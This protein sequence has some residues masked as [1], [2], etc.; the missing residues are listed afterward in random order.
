MRA[1]LLVGFVTNQLREMPKL[2]NCWVGGG[3]GQNDL[4]DAGLVG[5]VTH[6]LCTAASKLVAV[7]LDGVRRCS[8]AVVAL[9]MVLTLVDARGGRLMAWVSPRGDELPHMSLSH[10]GA[11]CGSVCHVSTCLFRPT[12]CRSDRTTATMVAFTR[13][14]SD[15]LVDA[16]LT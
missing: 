2:D 10:R 13:K 12:M 16:D 4:A 6:L 15:V 8:A 1:K 7:A 5:P 14:S 11:W 3:L 9:L